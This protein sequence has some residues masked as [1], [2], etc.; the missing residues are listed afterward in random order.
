MSEYTPD[1]RRLSRII[2][3]EL[4]EDHMSVDALAAINQAL[5]WAGLAVYGRED[6][7][8]V[9]MMIDYVIDRGQY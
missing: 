1:F 9:K 8:I 5:I 4:S 3:D 7:D 2:S 6:K